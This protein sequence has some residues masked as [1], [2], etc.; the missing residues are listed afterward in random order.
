MS[1]PPSP[2]DRAIQYGHPCHFIYERIEPKA[3]AATRRNVALSRL[4]LV[5]MI[6][7]LSGLTQSIRVTRCFPD[8]QEDWG[9]SGSRLGRLLSVADFLVRWEAEGGLCELTRLDREFESKLSSAAV[10]LV[11]RLVSMS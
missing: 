10:K 4:V 1:T 2:G 7:T 6:V 9:S 5:R 11:A 8:L 3:I